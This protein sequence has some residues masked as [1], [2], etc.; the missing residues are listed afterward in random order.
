MGLP[1]NYL[2]TPGSLK[3]Y[4]DALLNAHPPERFSAEFLEGLGFEKTNDR[5]LIG[6]LKELG[7][8]DQDGVPK[9]RYFEFLD[10]SSS[11]RILAQ[12]V[13]ESYSD[14]FAVKRNANEVTSAEV[15][16]KLRT[17]YKG[18]K[19]DFV[20]KRIAR[21]FDALCKEADFSKPHQQ[22]AKLD[23]T[24]KAEAKTDVP[25]K[26]ADR[27]ETKVKPPVESKPRVKVDSL[28]YHINIVLP[29]SRDSEVYDA[30]FKSLKA[31][32]G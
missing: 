13:R 12:A 26:P 20:I 14:L 5:L 18:K 19:T 22:T 3:A 6:V 29:E 23:E 32:L 30:I 31:H 2:Q 11:G 27:D 16:N 15:Q 17:L 24:R 8:L 25:A 28:Q 10:R 21:T 4:L 7:F 9:Q 1:D